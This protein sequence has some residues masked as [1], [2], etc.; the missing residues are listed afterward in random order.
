M[1]VYVSVAA[2]EYGGVAPPVG[3]HVI[4]STYEPPPR[5]LILSL[6]ESENHVPL[7]KELGVDESCSRP[8]FVIVSV[9]LL[10]V[11]TVPNAMVAPGEGL[12]VY[13]GPTVSQMIV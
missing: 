4:V 12:E 1:V 3:R 11:E 9:M 8:V 13:T 5:R 10:E 7:P 6:F 2:C